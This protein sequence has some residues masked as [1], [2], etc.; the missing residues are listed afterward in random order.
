MDP[1]ILESSNGQNDMRGQPTTPRNADNIPA[2]D[3]KSTFCV[4]HVCHRKHH[5]LFLFFLW[6]TFLS[7]L[8]CIHKYRFPVKL[9]DRE[10]TSSSS[11]SL[12]NL[13]LF[14][15]DILER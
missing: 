3:H 12:V 8:L 15:V 1:S 9:L 7:S 2:F 14:N 11:F 4:T 5:M 10:R 6:A 13:A